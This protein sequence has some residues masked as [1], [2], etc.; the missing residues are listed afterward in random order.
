MAEKVLMWFFIALLVP[1]AHA[2][3]A[4]FYIL[5]LEPESLNAGEAAQL[6]I[7]LKNLGTRYAYSLRAYL[8][9][10]DASPID[11]ISSEKKFIGKAQEAEPTQ[12]FG[13]V[14]QGEEITISFQVKA[15]PGTAEKVYLTPLILEWVDDELLQKKQ[16]INMGFFVRKVEPAIEVMLEAPKAVRAGEDFKIALALRNTGNDRAKNINMVLNS[17]DSLLPVMPPNNLRVEKLEVGESAVVR[18]TLTVSE[19]APKGLYSAILALEYDGEGSAS[20]R[21][22]EIIPI[23]VK[24]YAKLNIA[25]L[26]IEPANP[27]EGEE[28][29]VE[30]RV[31]NVGYGDAEEIK[32]V[33]ESELPGF[34]TA[35]I[36]KLKKDEDSPAI[37]ILSADRA[38][39]IKSNMLLNYTDDFGAHST[40]EKV[41]FDVS[42]RNAKGYVPIALLSAAAVA[43]LAYYLRRK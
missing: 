38:G 34:K 9:P 26:K 19:K 25:S 20:K 15:K 1:A 7:T 4:D 29:K 22:T 16:T 5:K 3:D 8:D 36:G 11:A 17:S 43:L 18:F 28:I 39:T 23:T 2:T 10:A 14:R 27:R 42:A 12:Y 40:A 33:L 41:Q 13:L 24:N 32:L 6:N 35:Y 30:V 37:F 31:E 21:Q